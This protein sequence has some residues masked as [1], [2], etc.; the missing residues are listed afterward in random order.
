MKSRLLARNENMIG[1]GESK[2]IMTFPTCSKPYMSL[3]C[4]NFKFCNLRLFFPLQ[5]QT[6]ACNIKHPLDGA[7][8]GGCAGPALAKATFLVMRK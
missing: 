6:L 4:T 2:A 3:T 7:V 5:I 1:E 8:L